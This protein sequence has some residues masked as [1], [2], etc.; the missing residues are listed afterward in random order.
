MA[1]RPADPEPAAQV[2]LFPSLPREI[3]AGEYGRCL[4]G[5]PAPEGTWGPPMLEEVQL[6]DGG[7]ASLRSDELWHCRRC[8]ARAFGDYARRL[9][10][11]H[12]FEFDLGLL[13]A[14]PHRWSAE[15][16]LRSRG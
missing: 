12:Q 9:S 16:P 5:R 2:Y 3:A 13:R 15:T 4:C 1:T 10:M 6:E 8:S 14:Y 11:V 7:R